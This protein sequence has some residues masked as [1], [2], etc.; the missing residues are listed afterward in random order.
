MISSWFLASHKGSY[1]IERWRQAAANYWYERTEYDS[2]FWVHIL[3]EQIYKADPHFKLIW[4]NVPKIS[5][6]NLF[7]FGPDSSALYDSPSPSHN[8]G[9]VRPPV[10]V[11]KLTHKLTK[12]IADSSLMRQILSFAK[13]EA[14]SK[15]SMSYRRVLITWYGSF[16]HGTIGDLHSMKS[17]ATYLH[18]IGHQIS[19]ATDLDV[20]ISGCR[21]IDWR[22]ADPDS[23]DCVVFVCGPIIRQHIQS[24]KLFTRFSSSRMAGVGVS[25]FS[26]DD[27]NYYNPFNTVFARQGGTKDYGDVAIVAP[28]P[29]TTERLT[30]KHNLRIGIILRGKQVEYGVDRCLWAQTEALVLKSA[31][32]AIRNAEGEIKVINNHLVH[33]KQSPDEIEQRYAECDLILTSRFHGAIESLRFGVPFIAIDQIKGGA[34]VMMLLSNLGWKYTYNI[35]D[36]NL[37]SIAKVM[38]SL[39]NDPIREQMLDAKNEAINR[40][41]ET[42]QS[43][44]EW[45]EEV[46]GKND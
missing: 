15:T 41:N 35:D 12:Q 38:S 21:R 4:D 17:V 34:K 28:M 29:L 44:G 30:R 3:F 36:I 6:A 40:A 14:I 2:Y 23:F 10:P 39:I 24:N 25:I 18:A 42:L 16:G 8:I 13:Q 20:E 45:V 33:S 1:V 43:L 46:S 5:A 31:W 32:A 11:F 19:H 27:P 26:P 22:T 7:H 9:L 37:E